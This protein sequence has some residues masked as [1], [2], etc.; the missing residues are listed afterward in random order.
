MKRINRLSI[1]LFLLVLTLL[2][3]GGIQ[4]FHA[5]QQPMLPRDWNEIK[6]EGIL[7]IAVDYNQTSYYVSG[8]TIAGFEYE[9]CR[10]L[11]Q[12]YG[13]RVE[14][15]PETSLAATLQG[16]LAGK[17]D[18]VARSIPI[19]VEN[20]EKFGFTDPILLNRLVLIQRT[21]RA[22]NGIEPI[23]NQLE[24]AGKKV[25]IP[26]EAASRERIHNL[27]VE[28]ADSIF[29]EEDSLYGEEQLIMRVAGGEIDYAI[30]D[31]MLARTLRNNYPQL[32]ILTAISFNQFRGWAIRKESTAL[33][34]SLNN[35][36]HR[37]ISTKDFLE[38]KKRY[39]P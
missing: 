37:K 12:D 28:I 3:M 39:I 29:L 4:L 11:E 23:R 38:K 14:I 20:K 5:L 27:S 25:Y 9:L 2:I 19:T 34:D 8:D 33:K 35:W 13:L 7:R 21:A 32:D 22:N 24:L 6:E 15:Y 17:Y 36:L 10:S 26:A 18:V 31:E 16:L 1:Y 30:C